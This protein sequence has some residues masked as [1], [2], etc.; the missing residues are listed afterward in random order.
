MTSQTR[1]WPG[2]NARAGQAWYIWCKN[3][4]LNIEECVPC[5]SDSMAYVSPISVWDIKELLRMM[6]IL[7]GTT[8]A[9]MKPHKIRTYCRPPIYK[10]IFHFLKMCPVALFCKCKLWNLSCTV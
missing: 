3:L 6:S 9:Q 5:D 2:L 1:R 8:I 4:A 10:H 7:A